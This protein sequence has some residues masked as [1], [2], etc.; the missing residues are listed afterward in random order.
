MVSAIECYRIRCF[1]SFVP[2]Y[3]QAIAVI[4]AH[5]KPFSQGASEVAA[6]FRCS[7]CSAV[8]PVGRDEAIIDAR[9][10]GVL[11]GLPKVD[12]YLVK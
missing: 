10:R 5:N 6:Y 8:T 11:R 3:S 12:E 7:C 4:L 9:S 2:N 1:L